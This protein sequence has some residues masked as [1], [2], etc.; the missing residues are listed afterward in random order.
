MAR[1]VRQKLLRQYIRSR[2]V[3]KRLLHNRKSWILVAVGALLLLLIPLL[4]YRHFL[5]SPRGKGNI[6]KVVDFSSGSSIKRISEEL[7]KARI[8]SSSSLFILFARL[9]NADERAKAGTYRFSD[10]MTPRQILSMLEAGD[11]YELRFSV[12]EG[13]SIY[14]IAELLHNRGFFKKEFFLRQC[15]NPALLAELGIQAKSVEGFLSPSTYTIRPNTDESTL[16]REMVTRF[17]S[18]YNRTFGEPTR[19]PG[20]HQ[21]EI[22]T[23]ASM[24][25]KEAVVPEERPII[26]SVFYNRLRMKMPLQSDPTAI[27]GVRAFAGKITK[28]DILRDTP[29]NTYRI[30]G[31]PPG[32]I[33]NPSIDAIKAV[34]HPAQ[35]H[36][37]YFVA[38]M[39]GTHQFSTTLEEHNQAVQKY[40]KGQEQPEILSETS[41]P[42]IRT[43]RPSLFSAEEMGGDALFVPSE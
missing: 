15:F 43:D 32:P 35:T 3:T 9:E 10:A 7:A 28:R 14:Q 18:T 20:L 11:V 17:R 30:K 19:I 34:L 23:L 2:R 27:Y 24:I 26:A 4:S 33:G 36:Y 31:L 12:P 21:S 41:G 22:L 40:L 8:I 16:I 39:D 29:Y 37:L 1:K 6:I 13:Y 42:E 25:E 38:R 5:Q